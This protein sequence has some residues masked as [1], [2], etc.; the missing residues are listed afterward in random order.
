MAKQKT[1]K[2]EKFEKQDFNIF[3]ALEAVDK[4]NYG[5]YDSLSPEQ[6]KKFSPYM[7]ILWTSAVSSP[8]FQREYLTSTNIIAN[9]YLFNENVMKHPKLQWM[10]L[11]ASSPGMGKQYHQWIPHIRER[12]SKLQ[13]DLKSDEIKDY[14]AKIYPNVDKDLINEISSMYI[15]VH[16]K[17]RYLAKQF[18][19]MKL[20]EIDLLNELVTDD[21]IEKYQKESGDN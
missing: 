8:K 12:V 7:L 1:P 9:R 10:M 13:D 2:D 18:P 21:E 19:N 15:K 16:K 14:Y 6:K 20:D 5:Y 4:K 11:C 17:K 3:E